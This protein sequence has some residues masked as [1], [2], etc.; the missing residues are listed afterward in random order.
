MLTLGGGLILK[1]PWSLFPLSLL[2]KLYFFFITFIFLI[3]SQEILSTTWLLTAQAVLFLGILNYLN[4][5]RAFVGQEPVSLLFVGGRFASA[6]LL[7]LTAATLYSVYI[8]NLFPEYTFRVKSQDFNRFIFRS[9]PPEGYTYTWSDRWRVAVPGYLDPLTRDLA[10]GIGIWS[11]QEGEKLIVSEKTWTASVKRYAF[12]GF[13][14]PYHLEKAVWEAGI[15]KPFLLP[16]KMTLVDEGV[17]AY[18][19]EDPGF[20]AMVIIRRTDTITGPAWQVS[21]NIHPSSTPYNIESSSSSLER[22]LFPVRMTLD[23]YSKH[24]IGN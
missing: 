14:D 20:N 21:A 17:Q 3:R 4:P 10:I 2:G 5:L 23:R 8:G 1:R 15:S 9:L 16:L 12:L 13:E 22:A 19:L 18:H 6:A 24:E 7:F 11:N